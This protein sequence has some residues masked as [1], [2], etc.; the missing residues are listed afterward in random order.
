MKSNLGVVGAGA[1]TALCLAAY[2]KNLPELLI[3]AVY[4]E[5][6]NRAEKMAVEF[7]ISKI[8]ASYD[9]LLSDPEINLVII[10]TPPNTHF[11]L[12]KQALEA[13]K[14]VLV[15]KPI[16]FTV[17]KATELVKLA[18][19]KKLQLAANFVLRFH[20]FHN[21][22][23]QAVLDKSFGN[24]KGINTSA[25]LAEYPKDHW[26]WNKEISGGFFLNTYCHFLDLYDFIA[27]LSPQNLGSAGSESTG[28]KI[29][30][31]YEDFSAE[32]STNLHVSGDEEKVVTEY[33][34]DD[35]TVKTEGWLPHKMTVTKSDGSV[36][37]KEINED[38][39]L[40]YQRILSEIFSEL[41]GRINNAVEKPRISNQTVLQSVLSATRSEQ[42]PLP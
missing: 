24:L 40:F 38:K 34:F 5:D 21:F 16:A 15:E 6:Q 25:A 8:A 3:K 41:L 29:V 10:L 35:A 4:D 18:N 12:A 26:Y 9:E 11:A 20:P 19:S 30:A 23:R 37:V 17:E 1:F 13:G 36:E 27:N 42:N 28:H 32:L 31:N 7:G 22:L 14:H 2:K 33:S 39:E